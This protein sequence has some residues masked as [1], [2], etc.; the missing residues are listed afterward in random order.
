MRYLALL[1]IVTMTIAFA[2][3]TF[4]ADDRTGDREFDFV[5]ASP[6]GPEGP[7]SMADQISF[8]QC[9]RSAENTCGDDGVVEFDHRSGFLGIGS[10]CSFTCGS[11]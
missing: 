2:L 5:I 3:P 6:I 9:R 4:A 8:N 11:E 7:G 1:A 10:R